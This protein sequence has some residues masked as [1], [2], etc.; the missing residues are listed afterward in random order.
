M[1]HCSWLDHLHKDKSQE[2][3]GLRTARKMHQ[4]ILER[5][6][7]CEVYA[8]PSQ[9]ARWLRQV[10]VQCL[11]VSTLALSSFLKF[12]K[13][14]MEKVWKSEQNISES[15]PLESCKGRSRQLMLLGW[16]VSLGN[17]SYSSRMCFHCRGRSVEIWDFRARLWLDIRSRQIVWT[18]FRDLHL[19]ENAATLKH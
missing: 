3:L 18:T 9:A 17:W 10:G 1:V 15:F 14:D 13:W 12:I 4:R 11:P 16:S 7:Q 6:S 5:L 2:T 19:Q 8:K